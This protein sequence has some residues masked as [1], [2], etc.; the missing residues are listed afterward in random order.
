MRQEKRGICGSAV[1]PLLTFPLYSPQLTLIHIADYWD[2]LWTG[3]RRLH[4]VICAEITTRGLRRT[5]LCTGPW[6]YPYV[7]GFICCQ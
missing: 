5:A 7:V 6:L 3:Q 4:I 1:N 2:V